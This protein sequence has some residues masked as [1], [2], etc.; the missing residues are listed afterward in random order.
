MS[1]ESKWA[2]YTF[3]ESISGEEVW[4]PWHVGRTARKSVELELDDDKGTGDETRARILICEASL[5]VTISFIGQNRAFLVGKV[6]D[7][8]NVAR[9]TSVN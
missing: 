6:G 7:I 9:T 3:E 5:V 8:R 4:R 2:V 1:A